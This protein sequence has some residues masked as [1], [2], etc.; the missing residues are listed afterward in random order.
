MLNIAGGNLLDNMSHFNT[1]KPSK[2]SAHT[3]L[4]GFKNSSW[5]VWLCVVLCS[6][7]RAA[8]QA[9]ALCSCQACKPT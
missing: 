5:A 1:S 6:R 7:C 2:S 4:G 9:P 3:R 8:A